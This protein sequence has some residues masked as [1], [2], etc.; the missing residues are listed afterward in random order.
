MRNSNDVQKISKS[1]SRKGQTVPSDTNVLV[2]ISLK[3]DRV[4][5]VLAAQGKDRE[6]Q[7]DILSAAGCESNFI[8]TVVGMT[9]G[10]VRTFQSRRKGKTDK[11]TDR[12]EATTVD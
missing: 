6:Q 4:I 3:L 2:E 10:A 5:A 7:I 11:L 1:C 12:G 8:G 9:G